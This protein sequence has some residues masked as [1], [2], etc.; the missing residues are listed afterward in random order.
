[1]PFTMIA[2]QRL[3]CC[4][5]LVLTSGCSLFAPSTQPLTIHTNENGAQIYVDGAMV[6]VGS[7]VVDVARTSH[8]VRAVLGDRESHSSVGTRVSALGVLDIIGGIL[9]LVP[10]IGIAGDGFMELDRTTVQL[11]IPPAQQPAVPA[12]TE[13]VETAKPVSE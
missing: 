1:M 3:A 10:F 8:H 2:I 13:P 7:A 11:T 4:T 5:A 9:F 12:V 6:G